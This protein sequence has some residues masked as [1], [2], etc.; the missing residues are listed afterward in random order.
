[1]GRVPRVLCSTGKCIYVHADASGAPL[2]P[3]KIGVLRQSDSPLNKIQTSGQRSHKCR[4][5]NAFFGIPYLTSTEF[6]EATHIL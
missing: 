5:I 3:I 1:M 6:V 2:Y 4:T